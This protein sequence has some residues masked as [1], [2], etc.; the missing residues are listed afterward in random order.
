MKEKNTVKGVFL[1][2]IGASSYGMLASFVKLAYKE[3]FTTAEV[4][5]AQVLLGLLGVFIINLCR[6]KKLNEI[7]PSLKDIRNLMLGGTSIGLTSVL[8]YIAVSYIDASIAVVL[9]MQSVW[10]GVVIESLITKSFPSQLKIACVVLILIGTILATNVLGSEIQ[11]DYR[12]AIFG[13]L[14]A[15]SFA[16]T[17]YSTGEIANHLAAPKRTMFM[18][19]GASAIVLLFAFITQIG[20]N[21]FEKMYLFY[22]SFS[23]NS[24]SV[25]DFDWRIFYSWGILLS[26][27]GTILPPIFLNMGFPITGVGLG[28]IVSSLELPASVTVAFFLL[29]ENVIFIQW[30]GILIILSSIVLMNSP[31]LFKEKQTTN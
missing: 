1:V 5:L 3:G 31:L 15:C 18:L 10:I 4:T 20:P 19:F 8:Y 16:A 26:L 29:G 9:L 17:M 7:D 27:F 11:L 2:A 14:G 28:S 23:D 24:S 25:R 21:N 30:L 12:G 13:F 6:K 22:Q